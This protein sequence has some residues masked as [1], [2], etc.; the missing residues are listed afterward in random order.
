MLESDSSSHLI[1]LKLDYN[2]H[3][4]PIQPLQ[5]AHHT[6]QPRKALLRPWITRRPR[7]GNCI[8]ALAH[9][10]TRKAQKMSDSAEVHSS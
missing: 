7:V 2:S 1:P 9:L 4:K 5:P 6:R 10:G 3:R 8:E